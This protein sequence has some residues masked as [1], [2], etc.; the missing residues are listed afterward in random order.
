MQGTH[1]DLDALLAERKLAPATVRLGRK[2]Y[3]VRTD[4]TSDEV[5]LYLRL[6]EKGKSLEAYTLLVGEKDAPVLEKTISQLPMVHVRA[7]MSKFMEASRAL[8]G[9]AAGDDWAENS[10]V[11][12]DGVGESSAS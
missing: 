10:D 5:V 9:F 1:F 3:K 12:E 8:A 2:T 11:S 4:L 7:V 6:A